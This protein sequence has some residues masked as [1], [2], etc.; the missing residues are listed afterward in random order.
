MLTILKTINIH[1]IKADCKYF[2]RTA[3]ETSKLDTNCPKLRKIFLQSCCFLADYSVLTHNYSS[4]GKFYI[5]I[6][7][8]GPVFECFLHVKWDIHMRVTWWYQ[9]GYSS[10]GPYI[11]C[12]SK[13]K[14]KT[15]INN[16]YFSY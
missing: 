5:F 9:V 7:I 8:G 15:S 10:M 12:K 4:E 11:I 13:T 3:L 14:S 1:Q 6:I 2:L 16:L